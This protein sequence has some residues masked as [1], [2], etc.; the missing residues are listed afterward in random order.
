MVNVER[1]TENVSS[2]ERWAAFVA[3]ESTDLEAVSGGY[4]I[5]GVTGQCAGGSVAFVTDTGQVLCLVES[6]GIWREM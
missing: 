5:G 6:T 2:T 3:C 1:S 4:R